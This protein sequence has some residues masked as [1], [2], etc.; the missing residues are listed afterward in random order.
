MLR[1]KIL[2]NVRFRG[3]FRTYQQQILD[4]ADKY[5]EDGRIHI[6]A[7]PGSGKTVLG[8]ELICRL[9]KRALILSPTT[10]IRNQWGSRF[11]DS[12]VG[13]SGHV[14][15]DIRYPSNITS[16]TYQALYSAMRQ[17][18]DEEDGS[19]YSSV[20]LLA[21]IKEND[22]RTICLDEAHH[23]QNEWQ[24]ALEAFLKS[25]EG[26]KIIALTATPPYD[27]TPNEWERYIAVCGEIDEEIFIPE[28]VKSG[29]L[30]PH[31]DYIYFNFPTEQE[32]QMFDA[33]RMR[34]AS[35]MSDFYNT[36]Y[37][38]IGYER[39][40]E[41]ERDYDFLYNNVKGVAAFLLLCEHAGIK[42]DNGLLRRL[43]IRRPFTVTAER[44]ETGIDFLIKVLLREEESQDCLNLFKRHEVVERGK[45]SLDLDER[46]RKRL[47]SS[48]G[49]LKGIEEIVFH[50]N[51]YMGN[52]LR[53][54]ILTDYIKKES[55]S[56]IGTDRE[57][58]CVSVVSV[59]ETA[60]RTG[61]SSG[62]VSGS[63]VILPRSCAERLRE[64]GAQFRM[65]DTSDKD[66]C[67]YEFQGSNLEKV[68]YV[69]R[70]F[71]EGKINVLVGTKSLLG[72]GWDAPFVNT[73][74]L[75]SFVGSFMLSNQMRGRA[76]RVYDGQ[77][78]KTSNIWHLVTIE[79]PHLTTKSVYNRQILKIT[80]DKDAVQSYD[81]E[82]VSRRFE[83]FIGPDYQTGDIRS[84]IERISAI[85]PPYDEKGVERINREMFDRASSR[86]ELWRVW[87]DALD[88]SSARV[89]EVSEV[90][91]KNIGRFPYL[92][93][94]ALTLLFVLA[95]MQVMFSVAINSLTASLRAIEDITFLNVLFI[96]VLFVLAFVLFV[97]AINLFFWKLLSWLS[98]KKSM[99][100]LS[101]CILKTMQDLSLI[102]KDAYVSANK[103]MSGAAV[104]I[105]LLNAS[106]HDQ[107]LFHR[108]LTDMF[109][110]IRNPRYILIP[111]F[112]CFNS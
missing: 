78:Q 106:V 21:I 38:K 51:E 55:V 90:P 82:T 19:D 34:A 44:L 39:L 1:E 49:K 61:V 2:K 75:A 42:T 100:K 91:E 58:D 47:I 107:A 71:E 52:N 70:L 68:G 67:I 81:F 40:K 27:A 95:I 50:E 22:I 73:L 63:L 86:D 98:P 43:A 17:K 80:E 4:R 66:T 20:D 6:V 65:T 88:N 15:Y 103:T 14:S 7:P 18:C 45:V 112:L 28:L 3:Q 110:P 23:L 60:R 62:A 72:E 26:I 89:N 92:F 33:Y 53:M 84:G 54:L 46:L 12:F 57:A 9:G 56:I 74:I 94:N 41:R 31:Q 77:R 104:S 36:E 25:V 108:A 5:L 85:R 10:T 35:A 105:E 76:I 59:Y 13:G 93:V 11:A 97:L 99:E 87:H 96:I 109:S 111:E 8:L 64:Y 16:I 79:R 83:T 30:C 37:I 69:S 101:R 29:S 24:K 48:V 32:T 102:S